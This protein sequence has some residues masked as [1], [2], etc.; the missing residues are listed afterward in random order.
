MKQEKGKNTIIIVLLVI[1][2]ALVAFIVLL[3]TNTINIRLNNNTN[4]GV[5][6]SGKD[7]TVDN[8]D[9]IDYDAEAIA[10][11]KMPV[12]I[13]LAN[14]E[15][16]DSVYC[17]AFVDDDMITIDTNIDYVK[18]IMDASSKF[19]TL[20]ELKNHLKNNLSEEIINN[21]FK[22]KENSYLEK[23]GKL[24]CQRAHKGIEWIFTSNEDKIN[25]LNPIT[26]T[27]SNKQTNSFDIKIE[28]KYG[29]MGS[30][31]R[32]QLVT[33]NGTIVKENGNWLVSK[34]EQE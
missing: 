17:G 29:F 4:N 27:I 1:V 33:I 18:I 20:E 16:I 3:L 9:A 12:A 22:T 28:A 5:E 15:K 31:E 11:E 26:Y 23:D 8:N 30:T 14:Q 21:Y 10:R 19:K 24:Y 13:S 32:D 6:A 34:Y 2:V 7:N 25:E